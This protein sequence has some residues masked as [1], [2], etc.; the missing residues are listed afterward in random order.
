MRSAAAVGDAGLS[1]NSGGNAISIITCDS[2]SLYTKTLRQRT[3]S[4]PPGVARKDLIVEALVWLRL[5]SCIIDGEAVVCDDN[6]VASF[7]RVRY[8]H[9]DKSIFLYALT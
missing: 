4:L 8:R 1:D 2:D 9:H 3:L 6:D 5:R 7:D